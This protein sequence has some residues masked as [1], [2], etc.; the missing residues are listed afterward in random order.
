MLLRLR[1]RT[2]LGATLEEVLSS[3]ANKLEAAGGRLYLTGL[4]EAAHREVSRIAKLEISW[5]ARLYEVTP[6][7]GESTREARE[8][9]EAWLVRK[10]SG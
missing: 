6:I 4:S 3:S 1:G 9:A 2:T 5:P 10:R 8:H 7:I